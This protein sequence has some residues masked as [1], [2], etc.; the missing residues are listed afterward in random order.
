[1]ESLLFV[2]Y[3]NNLDENAGNMISSNFAFPLKLVLLLI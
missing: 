1:M 3:S 2:V